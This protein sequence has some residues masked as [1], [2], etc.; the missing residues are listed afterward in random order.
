MSFIDWN[1]FHHH[2]TFFYLQQSETA[3]E[4]AQRK[5]LKDI[6]QIVQQYNHKSPR[7]MTNSKYPEK[8]VDDT[9]EEEFDVDAIMKD[10][11]Y[12]R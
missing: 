3:L 2:H 8:S 4:I 12:N 11:T 1:R 9:T 10:P 6:I 5:N 7:M